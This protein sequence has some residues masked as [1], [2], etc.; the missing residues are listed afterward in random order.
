M[1]R[2]GHSL[3]EL[4][5]VV[6]LLGILAA[7]AL[8]S[9]R[10]ATDRAAVRAARQELLRTLDAAR[11][12]AIRHGTA[13]A[14][15]LR[16]D[17]WVVFDPADADSSAMHTA[18]GPGHFG[19]GMSGAGA[20]IAFGPAGIAVGAANRTVTLSRG[21]AAATVVLSRLGRIR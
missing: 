15:H 18:N 10:N 14:V 5:L 1:T 2:R 3:L 12:A 13:S 7:I 17:Q 6:V 8:P 20:P 16:G 11:G 9:L 4:L 21:D 19:V